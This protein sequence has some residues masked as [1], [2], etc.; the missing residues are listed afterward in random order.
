MS[1]IHKEFTK[2]LIALMDKYSA[3]IRVPNDENEMI[4]EFDGFSIE[5][6]KLGTYVDNSQYELQ[7]LDLTEDT[8]E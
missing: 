6:L 8:N 3:E 5:N 7:E 2:E 1:K 4:V